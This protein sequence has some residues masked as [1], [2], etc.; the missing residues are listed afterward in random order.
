ML[1]KFFNFKQ[2]NYRFSCMT[3]KT[4]GFHTIIEANDLQQAIQIAEKNGIYFDGVS[5]GLDCDCCGDRWL[6]SP[7][8]YDDLDS[9]LTDKKVRFLIGF[10]SSIANVF[11]SSE[12]TSI[13]I[14]HL[15]GTTQYAEI[16][17]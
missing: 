7:E 9:F 8:E 3:S 14:H 10:D 17:K 11:H 15:N 4:F 6:N 16:K 2:N 5:K 12:K 13:I 1:T